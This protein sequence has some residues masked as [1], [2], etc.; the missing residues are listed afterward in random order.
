MNKVDVF[1]K[2][3]QY[4]KT[5]R[6]VENIKILINLLPDY[7]FEVAASS[8]GKYHPEF[9]LGNGGL[10][11]HTKAAVRIGY[12]LLVNNTISSKFKQEEKDLML[13]GLLIH[14]GLK[15]G[16]ENSEYTVFDHPL[17]ISKFIK[18]N[19]ALL[20]FTDGEIEFLCNVVESHMG[21]WT[22][23]YKG[24]EVL[25]KPVN[26]YQKFVHMCDY[27]ASRKFLNIKFAGNE[28]IE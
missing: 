23:D 28:I 26:K 9:T 18:D 10:V 6:Y 22:K 14:D 11:R 1:K 25:P 3:Y 4:I 7:F 15:H 17:Q 24:N 20:T 5:Q 27:L 21:E 16:I 13:C 8:T 19:R 12:E 2:E